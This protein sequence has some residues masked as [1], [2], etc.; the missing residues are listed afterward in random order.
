MDMQPYLLGVVAGVNAG[1]QYCWA[2]GSTSMPVNIVPTTE[3]RYYAVFAND[4]WRISCRLTL[5]FGLRYEHSSPFDEAQ[6]RM[7]A[8]LD[9][10]K[11]N[12]II[13]GV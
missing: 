5:N 7:T 3:D 12:T 8:P 2:C 6:N 10:T 11:P 13:Q 9:L 4:D 1:N